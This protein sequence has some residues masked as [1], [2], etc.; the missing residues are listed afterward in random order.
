MHTVTF[1]KVSPDTKFFLR[2]SRESTIIDS[3]IGMED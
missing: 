1:H 3:K 2:I